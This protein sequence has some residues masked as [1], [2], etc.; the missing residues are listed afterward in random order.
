M[1]PTCRVFRMN[2]IHQ[3]IL[4]PKVDSW[5]LRCGFLMP[6]RWALRSKNK[7]NEKK[8]KSIST[9]RSTNAFL[10]WIQYHNGG[11]DLL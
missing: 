1:T 9:D 8:N 4:T 7:H 3:L 5:I 10:F 11:K 6:L 2:E